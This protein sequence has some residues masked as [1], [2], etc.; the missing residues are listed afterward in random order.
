MSTQCHGTTICSLQYYLFVGAAFSLGW[1]GWD[2]WLEA[3]WITVS[4]SHVKPWGCIHESII[5]AGKRQSQIFICLF[6]CI[7]IYIYYFFLHIYINIYINVHCIY[8]IYII[9]TYVYIY[10]YRSAFRKICILALTV[11][12]P[13]PG[14]LYNRTLYYIILYYIILNIWW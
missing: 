9:Y 13:D 5:V 4:V 12:S 1:E 3:L 10:F 2:M 6:M 7:C 11:Y 8:Y 14:L